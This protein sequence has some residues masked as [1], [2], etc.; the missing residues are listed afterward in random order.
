M[1]DA[2]T[3]VVSQA[4]TQG[5]L[6]GNAQIDALMAMVKEGSKRTD[7]VNRDRHQCRS[8]IV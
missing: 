3:K 7:I 2:F 1:L 5:Q 4:D 6:V 8:S